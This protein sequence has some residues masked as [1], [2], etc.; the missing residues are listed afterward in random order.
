MLDLR[1]SFPAQFSPGI[2][3]DKTMNDKFM[4]IPNDDKQNIPSI[5]LQLV[6]ETFGHST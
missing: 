4:Y 5:Q 1:Y 2:L 3:R 6:V